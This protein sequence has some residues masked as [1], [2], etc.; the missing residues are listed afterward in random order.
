MFSN[1]LMCD[2]IAHIYVTS[3]AALD[4]EQ[5]QQTFSTGKHSDIDTRKE[6]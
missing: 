1:P 5:A 2:I 3:K 4:R 6:T